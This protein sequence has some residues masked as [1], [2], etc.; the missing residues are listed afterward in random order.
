MRS[1]TRNN[2]FLVAAAALVGIACAA[3]P[4]AP[5]TLEQVMSSPFPTE[6]TAAPAGGGVAWVF[7]TRG[8]RNIWVA[9]P[10]EYKAKQLTAYTEDDGQEIA[11]LR[12][13]PDAQTLV[14]VRGGDFE[15][16]REYP[17]PRSYPQ[18][19]EQAIWVVS[20]RG[21]PPR[22]PRRPDRLARGTR[23]RSAGRS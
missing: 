16:S 5:F 13:T 19:V 7:N 4:R 12:W 20:L 9:E 6:L 8:A 22:R 14:Y 11:E 2:L 18:G 15:T 21:G 3:V 17:N 10:P 1:W 23:I